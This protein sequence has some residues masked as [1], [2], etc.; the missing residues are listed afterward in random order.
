MDYD[1]TNSL[2]RCN[3]TPVINLPTANKQ[4]ASPNTCPMA[5]NSVSSTTSNITITT[6]R[7]R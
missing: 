6:S 7:S 2:K 3:S 1:P 4:I 5:T